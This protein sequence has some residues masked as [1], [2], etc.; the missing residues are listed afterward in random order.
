MTGTDGI[1]LI[2]TD[3]D[4]TLLDD[5][6]RIS[7]RTRAALDAARDAGIATIPVTARQPIGLRPIAEQAG[8]DS[9]A[10]CGNG[11]YGL[12]LTTGEQLFAEEIPAAVQAELAQ[13]L[14]ASIPDL[15]FASVRDAGEVFVAQHGYAE[16]AQQSDHKRDP[17]T[18]GGVALD[19][20]LGSPSLKLVIRHASVPIDDIFAALQ[21]LGLTG[22]AATL[23]GA[24]FVEVMAQGV[25]KATGLAQVCQRLRIE[26]GEVLAFGD[27][28]NDLE[29][30]QWAG[31]GVAMA[32]AIDV[33]RDAADEVTVTN[34]DDGVASV[35][36]RMLGG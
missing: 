13:A 34:A 24:P 21:A 14:L 31:R 25:T 11:A 20:V 23:S 7:P 10:L 27:A 5:S 15:L 35:I 9:W 29:M 6:G 16:I 28:L 22:F 36:E 1:R 8:F 33:V 32:N 30:L 2:A 12:H 4:G 3:L 18:M 19:E 26:A 17:R